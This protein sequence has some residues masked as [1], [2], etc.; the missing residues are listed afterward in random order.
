MLGRAG[1][2]MF[3]R[4]VNGPVDGEGG[5][6]GEVA[7][8]SSEGLGGEFEVVGSGADGVGSVDMA[9]APGESEGISSGPGLE[10][11]LLTSASGTRRLGISTASGQCT[12][13]QVE[14]RLDW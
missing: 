5:E 3:R 13:F 8:T 9:A 11:V 7:G 10:D 1:Q 14:S 12:P 6:P 4:G 2:R